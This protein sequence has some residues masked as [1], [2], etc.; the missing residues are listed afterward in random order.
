VTDGFTASSSFFY[1][2][3]AGTAHPL[4]RVEFLKF[5]VASQS[6]KNN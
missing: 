5:T 2:I 3:Q 4:M 1:T 6:L